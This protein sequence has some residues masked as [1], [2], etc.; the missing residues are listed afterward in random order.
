[1]LC[2]CCKDHAL[3]AYQF[4]YIA[5]TIPYFH[6]L[7]QL[8]RLTKRVHILLGSLNNAPE[9]IRCF[10]DQPDELQPFGL[11]KKRKLSMYQQW[12][13]VDFKTAEISQTARNSEF[14]VLQP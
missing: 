1:M 6:I 5:N 10:N 8:L 11:G 2:Y 3:Q 14:N 13:G 7:C 12:A 4:L 9:S